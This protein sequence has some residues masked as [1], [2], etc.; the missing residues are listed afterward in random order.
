MTTV[1]NLAAA[2]SGET[3]AEPPV[4]T[5]VE[6]RAGYIVLNRPRAINA[7]TLEMVRLITRTLEEWRH[8]DQVQ[9]VVLTGA[10]DRGLCAG[11]DIVAIH[12]DATSDQPAER[13]ASAMFWRE[14]YA[15][16]ALIATYPKP[17]VAVMDGIV[18]GGGVGVSAHGSHR[19]VTERTSVGMPETGIGFVPDVGGTW[20]LSR[21]PGQLGTH[22]ALT[23]GS[24]KAG[25]ALE[26]GLADWFVESSAIPALLAALAT[27]RPGVAIAAHASS[28]P[29]GQLEAE[30]DWIDACYSDN[31][32]PAIMKALRKHPSPAAQ[33]AADTLATRSPTA[34]AVTLRAL[35]SAAG[36]A[37]LEAAL[38]QELRLV[39]RFLDCAD[40]AEG[41]RAAVIDKDRDPSW[42]PKRPEDVWPEDID[43]FFAPLTHELAPSTGTPTSTEES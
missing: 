31:D 40:F 29:P 4:L 8:D 5:R 39:V 14:E 23:A 19:I 21:G 18:L 3:V 27:T 17:Y 30:R 12:R 15:L 1:T 26:L 42:Y 24:V 22:L 37:D 34:M 25:D 38:R 35:R 13:T 43:R 20:L 32:V 10:G 41:V 9:T 7:L 11:G 16:N 28:A 6:G 33:A 36:F 2:G